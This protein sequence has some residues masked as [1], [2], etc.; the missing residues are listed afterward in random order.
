MSVINIQQIHPYTPGRYEVIYTIRSGSL[1]R[2][3]VL[4]A[5]DELDAFKKAKKRL[6]KEYYKCFGK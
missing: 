2:R 6:I 4:E 5:L 3:Y 1:W